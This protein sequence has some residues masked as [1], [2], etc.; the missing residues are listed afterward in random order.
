MGRPANPA[1]S[2]RQ[3]DAA[4]KAK[5][6][7]EERSIVIPKLSTKGKAR[8]AAC[9]KSLIEFKR[10]YFPHLAYLE[11]G[12]FQYERLRMIEH[13]IRY[14]G[15]QAKAE[16]RGSA[17]STDAIIAALWALL[18]GYKKHF[19]VIRASAPEAHEMIKDV[20]AELE[21]NEALLEDFPEVCAPIRALDGAA[22]R[23]AQQTHEGERTHLAYQADRIILP[24]I[25]M[26]KPKGKKAIYSP[27]S[28]AVLSTAGITG[29]IRGR[30]IARHRPDFV[31]LDD[32]EEEESV[33]SEALTKK[34]EK[35]ITSSIGGLGGPG[36]S[37]ATLWLGTILKRGCLIDRYT[38][39]KEKPIWQGK[40]QSA[41]IKWPSSAAMQL[42]AKYEEL[43]CEGKGSGNDPDAREACRFY[44]ANREAMDAEAEVAW[45]A[46]F[47]ME[48]VSDGT[49]SELSAL[50]GLMNQRID[51][52][53]TAFLTEYQNDPPDPE[54][55][56]GLT[57][58]VV[59]SR[60]SLYPPRVI[61]QDYDFK[62]VQGIDIRGREIHFIVDALKADGSSATID[63][64]IITVDAPA[65]DLRNPRSSVRPALE[66]QILNALQS[67]KEV[68]DAHPYKTVEGTT[69]DVALTLVDSGWL[70]DIVYIFCR[71]AG[72]RFRATKGNQAAL[73]N[74]KFSM[75]IKAGPGVTLGRQWYAKRQND[76][77]ALYHLNADH[78]KMEAQERYSQSPDTPGAAMWFGN[79]AKEH[80]L[81]SKHIIAERWDVE[82]NKFNVL[83]RFNHFLDCKAMCRAAANMVGAILITDKAR[84]V[85]LADYRQRIRSN[86][87]NGGR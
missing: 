75:P 74:T 58:E 25:A 50:Q 52:G 68:M 36:K 7:A 33:E 28:G 87:V 62:L 27:A 71:Q 69:V 77:T 65:G 31:L 73:G 70:P 43:Y 18:Y 83:S 29:K 48:P 44:A 14:G 3:T 11:P 47:K 42:W 41:L 56:S 12:E 54:G 16:P 35:T 2:D 51:L 34:H 76:G 19:M 84:N 57:A 40:R 10:T 53:E 21:T 49:P 30:K 15:R 60:L 63:Y 26:S 61:P 64:D 38:D 5:R 45:P 55:E 82:A 6:R 24:K 1:T 66:R 86:W 32:I 9:A 39:R 13:M 22:Q 59:A 67:R 80:S 46:N 79:N 4:Y 72:A 81:I 78:W 20:K 17:K 23:A 8:R 85:P 37:V